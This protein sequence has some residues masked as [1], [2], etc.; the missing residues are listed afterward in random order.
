VTRIDSPGRPSGQLVPDQ[1]LP[2][3]GAVMVLGLLTDGLFNGATL[4]LNVPLWLGSLITLFVLVARG[5]G[6]RIGRVPAGLLGTALALSSM[7]AW[8]ASVELQVGLLGMSLVLLLLAL[9]IDD[10][11]RAR[12]ASITSFA[13]G[14]L[15]GAVSLFRGVV[16]LPRSMPWRSLLEQDDRAKQARA[17]GRAA[18]IALPLVLIFGALFVAADATFQD[19][20]G[21]S[22]S[23]DIAA[24]VRHLSWLVGGSAVAA[25]V[26]WCALGPEERV[27]A[28]PELA[29]ERRLRSV[30]TGVVLGS[31]VILFALFVVVQLQYLFGG[32][33]H[34]L[35]SAGLTYADYARRGFFELVAVA[36]LLLPVLLAADWARARTGRSLATYR[37]VAS[38]LVLLMAVVMAS[39]FERLRIYIDVFGLTALRFYAAALLAWLAT[40]F[41]WL[42]WSLLRERRDEFVIGAVSTALVALVLVVAV[43]PHGLIA[44]TNLARAEDG[45]DFDV[46]HALALSADATPTLIDG[47]E[48]VSD[49]DR[50][51]LAGALLTRDVEPA[52]DLRSW[53][54]GRSS[55]RAAVDAS[56]VE[57]V[58]AC[59]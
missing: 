33:D 50:C 57:L 16:R 44:A 1:W 28:G 19:W 51:E 17:V 2:V 43:N 31:L 32:R 23:V 54:W 6:R 41:A 45:R 26:L 49:E 3:V 42:L 46:S 10:D 13:A 25:G 27:P 40:V 22:L 36:V 56:Q 24:A 12:R 29:T 4:G 52:G 55:A 35:T 8:R 30:E 38:L 53:N 34:V 58:A 7:V 20:V 9:A 21:R 48:L 15:L 37:I 14:A 47:L 39:A 18:L 5:S 11:T 59:H